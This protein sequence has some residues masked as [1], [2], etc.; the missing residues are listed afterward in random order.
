MP[1]RMICLIAILAYFTTTSAQ[2]F[3][4]EPYRPQVHFSPKTSWMNDPNGLVYFQGVYH[5]FFQFYPDSTVWGPMHWGH[6]VSKDL[7]HW[8]QVAIALYPDSLGYIFSGSAVVDADNKS[9]FASSGKIPLVAVFTQHDPAGEKE[10]TNQ[11][12]NQSIAYSLDNGD[13]WTKYAGNPVL[14]TPGLKDFRDPKVSWYPEQNKWIMVLAAGDCVMFYSSKNLKNWEK[15]TEFG[16]R[17]GAHGGVWECPDLLPFIIDGKKIWLLIININPGGIQGGSGTQYFIGNFDGHQFTS[18][19]TITRWADYGPDNYAGVT[20]S[21]TGKEKIFL[22]WM[23]NWAYGTKVPTVKWRS[24][25]TIPRTLGLKKIGEHYFTTMMPVSALEKLVI[26]TA[27]YSHNAIESGIAISGPVRLEFS[28]SDLHSFSF[29]FSN[30][31]GQ[32]LKAGYD[33]EKNSFFIDRTRAGN[34]AFYPSF[35][36]IHYGPRIARS[37]DS[38]ITMILDNASLEL[39]ADQGLT[40]MTEIFFPDQP[41]NSIQQGVSRKPLDD[42]KISQL[43]SI[44]TQP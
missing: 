36:T 44:W 39:F 14:R 20:F 1:R 6:A 8:K 18:S 21:N 26:K 27:S 15:E 22:G 28:V 24:A 31:S 35:A 38:K 3:Y 23:S 41:Y 33:E 17:I 4:D 10:G 25:M 40:T 7:V 34:S 2:K 30:S 37:N 43:S 13:H 42:I 9:G 16:A 5:L 12:Q 32:S 11:F 19:D 29:T